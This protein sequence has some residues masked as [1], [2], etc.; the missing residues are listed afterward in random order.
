MISRGVNHQ[1]ATSC[2]MGFTGT[3]PTPNSQLRTL[4]LRYNP[5]FHAHRV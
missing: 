5:R 3:D 2:E 1:N 4:I